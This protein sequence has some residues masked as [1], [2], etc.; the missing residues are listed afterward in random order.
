MIILLILIGITIIGMFVAGYVSE[1]DNNKKKKI[2]KGLKFVFFEIIF[3]IVM[4]LVTF[5]EYKEDKTI[6]NN[7][8][9]PV[10]HEHWEFINKSAKLHSEAYCYICPNCKDLIELKD[11][12][13]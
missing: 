2:F 10:C 6:W 12:W 1:D 9:C 3:L 11:Y 4:F 13:K 7:G 5:L 8:F